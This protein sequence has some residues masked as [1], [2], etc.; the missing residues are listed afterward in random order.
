[1]II[2]GRE[3]GLR[4]TLG[5]ALEIAKLTPHGSIDEIGEVLGAGSFAEQLDLIMRF[6]AA[7]SNGYEA[8]RAFEEPGYAKRPLT[9][10]ELQTLDMSELRTLQHAAFAAFSQDTKTEVE[11]EES[12]KEEAPPRSA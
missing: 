9:Y 8:A 3:I 7:M 10:E 5:A 4:L 12:K 1:M 11:V 6:V 2:H